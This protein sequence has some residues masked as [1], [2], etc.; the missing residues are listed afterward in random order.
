MKEIP[1]FK[2]NI[3]SVSTDGKE[4]SGFKHASGDIGNRFKVGGKADFV[5]NEENPCCSLCNKD[6][7]FYAQIDSVGD[8]ITIADCGMIYVF[9]C[10][11]CNNSKSIIQ[12]F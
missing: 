9:V 3:E 7:T 11:D 1:E 5:Q 2:L 12:S 6:M 4:S 10:F 8:N